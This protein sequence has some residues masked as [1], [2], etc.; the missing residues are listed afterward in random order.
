MTDSISIK[1]VALIIVVIIILAFCSLRTNANIVINYNEL[2]DA[3]KL[4]VYIDGSEVCEIVEPGYLMDTYQG[5]VGLAIVELSELG[6]RRNN[7]VELYELR[8]YNR[9]EIISNIIV[10]SPESQSVIDKIE[11]RS[12]GGTWRKMDGRYVVLYE[13]GQYFLFGEKF[14]DDLSHA[15]AKNG[16]SGVN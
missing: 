8:F 4:E 7:L 13:N 1:R 16:I 9:G 5:I 2:L 3:E 12:L 10:L 6:V 14:F 11:E 15:L